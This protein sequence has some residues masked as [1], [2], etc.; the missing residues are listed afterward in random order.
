MTRGL[1]DAWDHSA[2]QLATD[3]GAVVIHATNR[4]LGKMW[5]YHNAILLKAI[6][7]AFSEKKLV[8][9]DRHWPS[10]QVYASVFRNGGQTPRAG[11]LFDRVLRRYG[12]VYINALPRSKGDHLKLYLQNRDPQHDYKINA[13]KRVVQAYHDM[14]W[15]IDPEFMLE[16][17]DELTPLHDNS[18][19]KTLALTGGCMNRW[20]T[21]HYDMF[22]D[23]PADVIDAALRKL[24]VADRFLHQWS[25]SS[26]IR[27]L[28]GCP[29]QAKVVMVGDTLNRN[30]FQNSRHEAFPFHDYSASS[31]FML[32]TLDKALVREEQLCWTNANHYEKSEAVILRVLSDGA[33]HLSAVALG[34]AA[35]SRCE[36]IGFRTIQTCHPSYAKRFG[37][38]DYP[39]IIKGVIRASINEPSVGNSSQATA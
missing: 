37:I 14:W 34:V 22:K 35:A 9:L 4:W 13:F 25:R 1:R 12:A 19:A 38:K 28:S 39:E 36:T 11:R 18:Y 33:P 17:T 15:G 24:D 8:V 3:Q 5:H 23:R 21:I 30:K 26:A 6:R 10:E 7:L 20:D 31:L 29:V 32:E 2:G 16:T 27:N